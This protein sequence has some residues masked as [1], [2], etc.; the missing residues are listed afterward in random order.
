MFFS[1][2][3]NHWRNG[4]IS[5]YTKCLPL[6]SPSPPLRICHMEATEISP[7]S[8]YGRTRTR[9]PLSTPDVLLPGAL[10]FG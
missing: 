1:F 9:R 2:Y 8:N 4:D 10:K 5:I 3:N 7:H 6:K